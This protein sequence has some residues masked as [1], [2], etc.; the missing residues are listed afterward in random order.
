MSPSTRSTWTLL[1]VPVLVSPV[2]A[3][4]VCPGQ[5]IAAGEPYA[6]EENLIE[7][8]FEWG[9]EVRIRDG[10]PVD[11]ATNALD[12]VDPVL[13]R[14]AWFEWQRICDVPEARLDEI[15]ARG[16]ANSGTPVYN[17]NNIYRLR[18]PKELDV[19]EISRE[20]EDLPGIMLARPVPKPTPAPIPSNWESSQQH[21]YPAS[22]NPTGI[23]AQYAWTQPGGD[24][25][26]VTVCDL[27]YGWKLHADLSKLPSSQIN[28]NP[29]FWPAGVD[30]FHG[31]AVVGEMVS[32][33][34][35]WGTKGICHGSGLKTCGTYYGN[36]ISWN[37]PG[38]MAYAIAALAPGDVIVLEQQWDYYGIGD[39][40]PIEWW[41]DYSPNPQ[42]Y[43]G[44]YAAIVNA[45]SN[46]I[47]VVEAGGNSR[48]TSVGVDTDLLT[49]YGDSGAIIVGAGGAW[50]NLSYPFFP[51]GDLE[52]I[53]ISAY[54]PRFSLQG[55][56][57][58]V[59]T[60]GYGTYYQEPPTD[61]YDY[62]STFNGTSAAAPIVAGAVACCVGHWTATVSP[63][64]PSTEYVR[65]LLVTTGTPQRF[66]PPGHI[67]PRPNLLAAFN[68]MST[69]W[70][71]RTHGPFAN[72][73][74]GE[75]VAW[76]D[77]DGDGDQDVYITNQNGTNVLCRND[78]GTFVDATSTPVGGAVNSWGAAWGDYENDGDV[79]LY[80]ANHGVS[81][82]MFRNDGWGFSDATYGPL[83]DTGSG[84]C[85]AWADYDLDGDIDLFLAR[86]SQSDKLLRNDGGGSF[87]DVTSTP[88]GDAGYAHGIAWGDYDN[89]GDPDLF[90][91][92]GG[93][94][95]LYR[96]DGGGSFTD[97]T[98]A[99]LVGT[100]RETGP[101]WGD[102]DNDGD[103]DLFVAND[104][105]NGNRLFRNEG[106]GTFSDQ[107]SAV[108]MGSST[109]YKNPAWGDYDNDG[110]LDLFVSNGSGFNKLFRNDGAGSFYDATTGPLG[111]VY[112]GMGAAWADYDGDG[113]LDLCVANLGAANKLFRN[114]VGIAN[115][116][117]HIN[118]VGIQSNKS[119]I[120]ARVRAVS[121]NLSQIREVS[122]GSGWCSQNSLTVEF[123][124]GHR[125][126]VD[127]VEIFWPGGTR[128]GVQ[129]LFDVAV[130]QVLTVEE[131][132]FAAVEDVAYDNRPAVFRLD[133]NFPN[134]FNPSTTIH[135]S[136]PEAGPVRVEIFDVAG[137]RIA[138][139]V[140][141]VQTSGEKYLPWNAEGFASGIY[142]LRVQAGSDVGTRKMILLK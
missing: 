27:E 136:L 68:A 128:G 124:V 58:S 76:G 101:A 110:D 6:C 42:S 119:G 13:E 86:L 8:M 72:T 47:H 103:L 131:E 16:E 25:T 133:R 3:W 11:L 38:A 30:T 67:G 5:A 116:W 79:D 44:V 108:L 140:D 102:Y 104:N 7:V 64:P 81:N 50:A 84:R 33:A 34:N 105:Y 59:L 91:S 4:T 70:T 117:L 23:D 36:P 45:V 82:H 130:D 71:D 134:P 142:L 73:S 107:T 78:A 52:R 17:L 90:V 138:V 12:G 49:W 53:Y 63:T 109:N 35:G 141:E 114:D 32:D 41:L 97:V 88:L 10:V 48:L 69:Q 31:T 19:W 20:L 21:C 22:A 125:T 137:R 39:H 121:G 87:T 29:L 55:W 46:G 120:G 118:L 75:G 126:K 115:H 62:T 24:G 9:S 85:V 92:N 61:Y 135:Y 93:A 111:A 56:G 127:T 96:N 112:G 66:G 83:G 60:T 37:V 99:L 100:N 65:N 15:Q 18:I 123:G 74:N 1:L 14:A 95:K 54:G 77:Y 40:I 51:E 98:P 2:L 94:S 106:G 89:D 132:A 113:D 28:P 57:E 122:G 129:R 43:N 80:V 26:G 139:L